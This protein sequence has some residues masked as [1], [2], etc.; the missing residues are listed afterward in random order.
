MRLKG[1]TDRVK[2]LYLPKEF[3]ETLSE[4]WA[5]YL[6]QREKSQASSSSGQPTAPCAGSTRADSGDSSYFCDFCDCKDEP[7]AICGRVERSKQFEI[8]DS[9]GFVLTAQLFGFLS[10]SFPCSSALVERRSK[11][12]LVD[13]AAVSLLLSSLFFVQAS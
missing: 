12:V 8:S 3:T 10:F 9:F 7:Q 11:P 5:M 4:K 2:F 13:L 1:M 6:T